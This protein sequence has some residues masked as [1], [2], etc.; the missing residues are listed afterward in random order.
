MKRLKRFIYVFMMLR[1]INKAR[2]NVLVKG[3]TTKTN[4]LRC[5]KT[6]EEVNNIKFDPFCSEHVDKV[7]GMGNYEDLFRKINLLLK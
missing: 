7:A 2:Y 3:I 4:G 5:I 6:F 1:A